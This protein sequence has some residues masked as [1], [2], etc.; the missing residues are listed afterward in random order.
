M[1][2]LSYKAEAA[3]KYDR[4]FAHVS[5]HFVLPAS[6]G[7]S[8][9]RPAGAGRR[10]RHRNRGGG[11]SR[12]GWPGR[13]R[14]GGRRLPSHGGSGTPAARRVTEHL[15]RGRGRAIAQFRRWQLSTWCCAASASCSS[16]TRRAA[17]RSSHRVLRPGGRAAV[18]VSTT[19]EHSYNGRINVIIGRRVASIAAGTTRTFTLGEEARLRSLFEAA[20]FRDVETTTEAYRFVL[21][22]FEAYFEPFGDDLRVVR[23]CVVGLAHGLR[24][25]RGTVEIAQAVTGMHAAADP[26]RPGAVPHTVFE[27]ATGSR[28]P[29]RRDRSPERARPAAAAGLRYARDVRRRL[30]HC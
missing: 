10:D 13:P 6:G 21:P 22:L 18:S 9:A 30:S 29:N 27:V 25:A 23:P 2:E 12:D 17:F 8:S 7:A 15:G 11:R 24:R 19:P 28:Y 1:S 14:Y 3:N 16:R 5:S 26:E 4:A 20:G